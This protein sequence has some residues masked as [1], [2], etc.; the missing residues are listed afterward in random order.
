MRK[1]SYVVIICS[2]THG[3]FMVLYHHGHLEIA[4]GHS[5]KAGFL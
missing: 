3:E 4:A 1:H 5:F 2:K